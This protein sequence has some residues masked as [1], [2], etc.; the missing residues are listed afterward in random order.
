MPL[1]QAVSIPMPMP[2][3]MLKDIAHNDHQ[4]QYPYQY[5]YPYPPHS[6]L[7]PNELIGFTL[8]L[9]VTTM[10]FY[11][12]WIICIIM[13]TVSSNVEAFGSMLQRQFKFKLPALALVSSR[14]PKSL[15]FW[16]WDDLSPPFAVVDAEEAL[17]D[18]E[19]EPPHVT[20][21]C[22]LIH[23]H[24]GLSK[25]LRYMQTVM[26]QLAGKER[27]RRWE[28]SCSS[29][30]NFDCDSSS[31]TSTSTNTSTGTSTS[32]STSTTTAPAEYLRHDMVVHNA[33][34]NEHKTTDGVSAGGDRLVDEMRQVIQQEMAKRSISSS[35]P[36]GGKDKTI[37]DITISIVGNSLGGLFGRYAIAKLVERHCTKQES[38]G[39]NDDNDNNNDDNNCWILDGTYRLHLN[40]FCTTATPHLGISRHTYVPIPRTA[41]IGVA[42]A[43]GDTGKD[44]FRLNNLIQT[45]ATC[46]TY[47]SP[48]S[49]FRKRI[50]YAN[51]YGTDFPVPAGTAAFLSENSTYPHHF[52]QHDEHDDD[53]DDDEEQHN[54]LIIATVHTPIQQQQPQIPLQDQNSSELLGEL[55][56][57]SE[58]LDRLGWKKVFVD[59]RR[60][61]PS[62]E[63][64]SLSLLRRQGSEKNKRLPLDAN[65]NLHALRQQRIVESRD[66]CS[67]M[68]SSDRISF[69]LGHNMICAF[70]RSPFSTFMYQ[71]GRPVVDSLAKEL[72]ADIFS[73]TNSN[74]NTSASTSASTAAS[75]KECGVV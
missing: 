69:P 35:L 52:V 63:V 38:G 45:M 70:S 22:F 32:T 46:P 5:Q 19:D 74:S 58:S 59:V 49:C 7:F 62:V 34:C 53:N 2:I 75:S 25:D 3:P 41:E 11:L 15:E 56:Q 10:L 44:L 51:A 73:W 50:A 43:M 23:G 40:I 71:G 17:L 67:A 12:L 48:L 14:I 24:R 61:L 37:Q 28:E 1:S 66:I 16:D 65:A 68:S 26:Q 9:L 47:L 33:V 60:E 31:S 20:H 64:P 8:P 27:R 36:S 30:S 29:S 4:H 6:W 55:H 57:M 42:H 54:G 18:D 72:V 39:D 13:A 21:F